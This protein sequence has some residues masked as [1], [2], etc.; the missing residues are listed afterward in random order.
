MAHRRPE[1]GPCDMVGLAGP[2]CEG[3]VVALGQTRVFCSV[4]FSR[5]EKNRSV[6]ETG[7]PDL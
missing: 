7:G 2:R 5:T 3:K 6:R 4:L 1:P